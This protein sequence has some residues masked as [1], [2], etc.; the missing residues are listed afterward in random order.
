MLRTPELYGPQLFV[1]TSGTEL[2]VVSGRL[3]RCLLRQRLDEIEDFLG[4]ARPKLISSLLRHYVV[5]LQ[6]HNYQQREVAAA[7]VEAL[8]DDLPDAIL[9]VDELDLLLEY[10]FQGFLGHA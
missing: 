5:V 8:V 2:L 9:A 4:N 6:T 10:E 3:V 1:V 7:D